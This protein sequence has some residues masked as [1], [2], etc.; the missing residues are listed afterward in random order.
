[1]ADTPSL[2]PHR[3]QVERM[4][5]A[6][7]KSPTDW[8]G[9]MAN[10]LVDHVQL[11]FADARDKGI[12]DEDL[13]KFAPFLLRAVAQNLCAALGMMPFDEHAPLLL[14]AAAAPQ[15]RPPIT[16]VTVEKRVTP[17]AGGRA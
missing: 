13:G 6:L 3:D 1:M 15:S 5:A 7:G 8:R 10:D 12:T 11:A 17:A 16:T 9:R 14:R 2:T 4:I